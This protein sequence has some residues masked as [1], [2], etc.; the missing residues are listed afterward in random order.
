MD[1]DGYFD[2]YVP[3]YLQHHDRG[4]LHLLRKE[5]IVW[6]MSL[7]RC[8]IDKGSEERIN[9]RRSTWIKDGLEELLKKEDSYSEFRSIVVSTDSSIDD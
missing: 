9:R 3:E 4:G 7:M 5:Y 6:A 2:K 1:N 8:C